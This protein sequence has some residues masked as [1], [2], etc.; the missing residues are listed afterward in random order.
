[1]TGPIFLIGYRG[2]GK[3]S[4]AK[5]LSAKLGWPWFDADAIL[6][7][8]AGKSIRQMFADE[9]ERAFRDLEARVLADLAETVRK[10]RR[11]G[12]RRGIAAGKSRRN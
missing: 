1:M 4:V 12:R 6:E 5:A 7:E 11:D 9:G 10:H 2:A 8:C 3:T